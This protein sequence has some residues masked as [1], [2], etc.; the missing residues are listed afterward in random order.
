[1][2]NT[3]ESH[4]MHAMSHAR[5]RPRKSSNISN[6]PEDCPAWGDG[7][8]PAAKSGELVA[9]R[10]A[11]RLPAAIMLRMLTRTLFIRD[12]GSSIKASTS[13]RAY[14]NSVSCEQNLWI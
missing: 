2:H 9:V 13:Y 1:M 5:S 12:G 6:I 3:G 4:V 10:G 8:P 7:P 14:D 11:A